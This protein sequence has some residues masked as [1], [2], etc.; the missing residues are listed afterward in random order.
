MNKEELKQFLVDANKAGYAS[1]ET[2]KWI[3][4][5]DGSTTIRYKKGSWEYDDNFFGGEPFGGRTVVFHEGRAVWMM[6]YYGW[7][8]EEIE[9]NSIFAILRNALAQIPEAYPYRGP[10]N[11]KEGEFTY[12]NSW[13][14]EVDRFTGSEQITKGN[15]MMYMADYMGGLV[16]QRKGV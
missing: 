16:D 15:K 10:E 12:S 11:Y 5:N 3:E 9:T 7:V 13:K 2:R 4:E 6:V 14:G 8:Q 1:G